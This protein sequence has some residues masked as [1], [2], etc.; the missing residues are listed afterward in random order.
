MANEKTYTAR[1]AA[2]EVLKK[3]Q[4]MLAKKAKKDNPDEKADADLGE[5][6]EEIVENHM[7]DNKE[8]EKKE[9]HKIMKDVKK[10]EDYMFKSEKMAEGVSGMHK[11]EYVRI[12]FAKSEN[13]IGTDAEKEKKQLVKD[14]SMAGDKKAPSNPMK[15]EVAPKQPQVGESEH[16]GKR[17]INEQAQTHSNQASHSGNPEWGSTPGKGVQ[18]L[19]VFLAAKGKKKE[20]QRG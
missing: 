16:P 4:E 19:G 1:E 14:E 2:F 13:E 10:S 3:A 5:K 8:A 20:A 11:I 6:V 18:K 15:P 9:G 17:D 12:N 7:L